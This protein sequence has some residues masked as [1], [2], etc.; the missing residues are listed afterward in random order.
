MWFFDTPGTSGGESIV[1]RIFFESKQPLWW[2]VSILQNFFE[3]MVSVIYDPSLVDAWQLD[4]SLELRK[5]QPTFVI[6]PSWWCSPK[7]NRVKVFLRL[8]RLHLSIDNWVPH[9]EMLL[10][11]HH[12][13]SK[14]FFHPAKFDNFKDDEISDFKTVS[15]THTVV[16]WGHTEGKNFVWKIYCFFPLNLRILPATDSD[17]STCRFWWK[18][19][20]KVNAKRPQISDEK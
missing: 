11:L 8:H 14:L 7:N 9:S 19:L 3:S 10:Y 20:Q 2:G 1:E 18:Y 4:E 6:M 5:I 15:V 12:R 17:G 16:K 13:N